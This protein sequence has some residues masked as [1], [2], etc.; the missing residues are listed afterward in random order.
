MTHRRKLRRALSAVHPIW[1]VN[2]ALVAAA[3]ALVLGP[4]Q[5]AAPIGSPQLSWFALAAVVAACELWPV[6]L[7]FRRSAHAFSLTDLPVALGLIF[8]T[9]TDFI[10]GLAVGTVAALIIARLPLIKIVFNVAQ[11]VVATGIGLVVLRLI[12][13]AQP[14][15]GPWLWVAI[16]VAMQ[17]SGV[18]TIGLLATAIGLAEGPLSRAELRQMLAFD[19]VVTLGNTSVALLAAV[20]VISEPAAVPILLVQVALAFAGY[21]AYA[22]ERERSE[23][24][25]FLYE[26]NRTLSHSP[27]V[28]DA[29]EGLLDRAREAFRA[30]H[31]ELILFSADDAT[32]FRTRLGPSGE[33]HSMEPID[34]CPR[35]RRSA[36]SSRMVPRRS[37]RRCRRASRR[38][39]RAA[40]SATRWLRFCGARSGSSA[41]SS[42]PTASASTAASRRRTSR[43]SR[44]SPPTPALRCSTTG[45]S[46]PSP[47]CRSCSTACITRPTTTRSPGW[48]T[49]PSSPIASARR[50]ARAAVSP[51]SSSISTTSRP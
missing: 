27:E 40:R 46:R 6:N 51:C 39:S 30:D 29:I 10:A 21:R 7:Q 36:T 38:S 13:G 50:S 48:R 9:G 49:G 17:L 11:Y 23:K 22:S 8:A 5:A 44:R 1:C 42:W 41:R 20:V 37:P 4:I 18:V 15:F 12:A 28:A 32:P 33:R 19:G 2:G 16:F 14:E 35:P 24:V 47:T 45:W 25:E 43:C 31:A 34:P 26:A 3:V